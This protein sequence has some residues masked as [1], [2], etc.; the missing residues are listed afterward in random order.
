[1]AFLVSLLLPVIATVFFF[2]AYPERAARGQAPMRLTT[3]AAIAQGALTGASALLFLALAGI[4][5]LAYRGKELTPAKVPAVT[6]WLS[7][8]VLTAAIGA[9]I[10]ALSA[11]ALLP[12][13]R[14]RLAGLPPSGA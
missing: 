10:G 6:F 11:L 13:V 8:F 14:G 2:R 1:M 7:Q 3:A 12:W 4:V 5:I 9:A